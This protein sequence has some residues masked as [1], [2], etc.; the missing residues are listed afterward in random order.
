M[1]QFIEAGRRFGRDLEKVNALKQ[2]MEDAGFV[3]VHE[4]IYK[5]PIGPWAKGKEVQGTG[6]IFPCTESL[7]EPR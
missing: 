5:V 7:R 4:E 3:D 6:E 2:Y 1:S